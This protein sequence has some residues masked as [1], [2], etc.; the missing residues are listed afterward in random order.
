MK[1]DSKLFEKNFQKHL[2]HSKKEFIFAPAFR[3]TNISNKA[4]Q[5]SF[6]D[7]HTRL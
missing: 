4:K 7:L 3:D 1:S 5:R 2:V 6:K